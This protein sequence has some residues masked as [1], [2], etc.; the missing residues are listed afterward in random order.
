MVRN[1]INLEINEVSSSLISDYIKKNKS[2]NL[3]KLLKNENLKIYTTKAIDIEKDKLFPAQTWASFNTGKAF[4]DHKCYWYSDNLNRDELIWNKLV[5][6]NK[7]VGVLGSIHSSK[8]PD[9]LLKNKNYKF[10]LP[11]CFSSKDLTKPI[12]YKA[13]QS[14]NNTLVGESSRVTGLKN[15]FQTLFSYLTK[16]L[17]S[18]KKFGIS[19]FS[20]KMI[21]SIISYSILYRNKEILRMAQFPLIASIFTD[22]YIKYTPSYS[23]LFSNHVAGN[24][25]RYWYAY[26]RSS[27][28]NQNKYP[29]KWIKKNK[30]IIP[31]SLDLLDNFI[32]HILSKEEFKESIILITSSMG[33]E[34]NPSFNQKFLSKYDGKIK[35]I[36]LFLDNFYS[37]Y[38][39]KFS[40]KIEFIFSRNMA[41]QYGFTIKNKTKKDISIVMKSLSDFVA[42]LGLLNKVNEEDGSIVLTIDPYTDMKFQEKY[43]LTEANDKLLRYGFHFFPIDDHHSGSHSEYGSLITINSTDEFDKKIDKYIEKKGYMN[44]L[45]YF[46][47]ITEYL[48][49]EIF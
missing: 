2:C 41:P 43:N 24:M 32:G 33:Q 20:T 47:L 25:H 27:F 19:F 18:P 17:I 3:S 46:K 35:E 29:N 14:L 34:A 21:L 12:A 13:F 10:Y 31:I 48:L 22:L 36:N 26:D 30:N 7:S 23:T 39:Q 4:A 40:E 9:D 44:Y 15:L 42:S 28:K 8:F 45:N 1:I 16:V 11:D 38:Y 6:K 37:F 49:N 5:F